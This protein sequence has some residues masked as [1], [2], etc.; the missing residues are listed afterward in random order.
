MNKGIQYLGWGLIAVIACM[1]PILLVS[2][3]SLVGLWVSVRIVR[4]AWTGE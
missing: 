2:V 4:H 3:L 1:N